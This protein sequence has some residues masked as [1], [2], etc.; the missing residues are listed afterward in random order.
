MLAAI[1]DE[2]S[3]AMAS[4]TRIPRADWVVQ[5]SG[6]AVLCVGSVCPAF[7]VLERFCFSFQM[8]SEIVTIYHVVVSLFL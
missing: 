2:I 1:R 8:V 3:R 4:Y 7:V 6:Q 5:H